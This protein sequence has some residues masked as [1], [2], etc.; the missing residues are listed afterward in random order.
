MVKIIVADSKLQCEHLLGQYLDESHYDTLIEEDTDCYM[1]SLFGTESR[2]NED[3]IAFKFRK[4]WFSKEEQD[5]AYVGLREAATESQNRGQAAGPRGEMLGVE[6]RGGRDW[7]TDYE[8]EVLDF[9]M[10]TSG[11]LIDD[12]TIASIRAKYAGAPRSSSDETRGSV[13]LRSKVCE[14]YPEYFGWFDKWVDSLDGKSEEE[15]VNAA[16]TVATKW[17][18][19]TNYAKS[20]FSGV[21]GWYDRYPRIPFGRATTYTRDNFDK[22]KL[23][24][25]FLQSL[26]RGFKELLPARWSN[27]KKAAGKI[28]P[29][30][31]VPDTVFTTITVNK[32]FRTAAHRDAGDFADGLS[33]LLVV[34]SGDYTG[35][36]LIFPEYRIAVNVRPGDLLL[37]SNHEI[38]HGNTEIKLT[39]PDAERISLVCYLRENMLDLGSFDYETTREQY[40]IDRRMNKEHKHHRPLWNGVSPGMWDEQEW[41]DYLETKLGRDTV[42]KYHP[43]ACA[44]SSSLEDLFG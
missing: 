36:Y 7:V 21:A 42:A 14:Q 40:V 25:P 35:G 29:K 27:Q 30:F 33:N 37:V 3:R 19:S 31:V 6:G 22:F 10:D 2:G 28:D 44:E 34:G 11:K 38:I 8:L 5:Q 12:V 15:I 9:L 17:V 41:Y 20:V 4:N 16:K 43:K 24:F 39:R 13:W 23:A 32:S 18:S 26:D 1:E